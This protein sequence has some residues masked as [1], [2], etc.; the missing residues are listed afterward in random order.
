MNKVF[1]GFTQQQT[2]V[3]A[4]KMGFTGAMDKFGD[5][6][7]SDPAHAQKLNIYTEK[8]RQLVAKSQ[9]P[10]YAGGGLVPPLGTN[11]PNTSS[12]TPPNNSDTTT[13]TSGSTTNIGNVLGNTA[14]MTL[15]NSMITSPLTN[16]TP[17]TVT[18]MTVAPDEIINSNTATVPVQPNVVAQTGTT[19]PAIT[20]VVASPAPQVATATSSGGLPAALSGTAAASTTVNP[21]GLVEAAT[22]AP[23]T[24]AT[25][26]GQLDKLMRQFDGGNTPTWAAGAI[27]NANAVMAARGL[28]SS[29]IAGGAV[30]QAAMESSLQIAM[31]DANTFS[32]FEMANLNNR[33]Q[34]RLQN[35]QAF[36]TV[37]LAN[38]DNEQQVV[39]FKA[40]ARVQSLFT[41]QAAENA[42][43]QFNASSQ[44]QTDQFFANLKTTVATF[45][46]AQS[47]AM[48]EFNAGQ[49]NSV[50]MFN[51]QMAD[52]R[53]QFETG[54]RLVIDQSNATWRR[55]VTTAN[56]AAVNE[57][58]RVNAQS[59]TQF[60][61]AAYNNL[62][63]RERDLY[64][65][66]YESSQNTLQRA[67]DIT[68]AKMQ[69]KAG[70][71]AAVGEAVGGLVATVLGNL[72]K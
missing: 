16:V 59:A 63:Q 28:G 52:A 4:R 30:T 3:L 36:L 8:A 23:T 48:S 54:N 20:D 1:G 22:A 9:V 58:N 71:K 72:F 35:A 60:T 45:N 56:N 69:A 57:A 19:A 47:N 7:N 42:S 17:T 68:L 26:V 21:N 5:F 29:S 31:Q 50:G 41:D 32:Q 14:G 12:V 6:L 2:E 46:A 27:R 18:P 40:Q 13:T 70:Q 43:R 33:Q 51:R 39:M 34:A 44:G 65:F 64:T 38:L 55:S 11:L 66:A 24:D 62:M 67:H 25:V 49:T 15:T 37:D 61:V 53:D 10:A